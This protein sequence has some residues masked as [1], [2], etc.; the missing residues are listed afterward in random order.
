MPK[1]EVKSYYE[2]AVDGIG[3]KINVIVGNLA[4]DASLKIE[5]LY[6]IDK[7]NDD[8]LMLFNDLIT[9]PRNIAAGE[10][11]LYVAIPKNIN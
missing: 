3:E 11:T 6:W 7:E 4:K 10:W 8:R 1:I 5:H 9:F 2:A